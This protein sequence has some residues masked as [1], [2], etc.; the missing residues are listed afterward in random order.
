MFGKEPEPT[1]SKKILFPEMISDTNQGEVIEIVRRRLRDKAA[2]RNQ[3]K[4]MNKQFI[5]YMVGHQVLVKEQRLSS[6]EDE[7]HKLFLLYK[8]PHTVTQV[9][10]NNTIAPT[11]HNVTTTNTPRHTTQ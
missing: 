6:A 7:I 8:G 11:I 2:I 4:D 5:K 1:I 10:D 9:Y 3:A